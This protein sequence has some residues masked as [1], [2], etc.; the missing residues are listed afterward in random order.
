MSQKDVEQLAVDLALDQWGFV[1]TAQ[2]VARGATTVQVRRLQQA[3][4][5]ERRAQGLHRLVRFP[6]DPHE[7]EHEAYIGLDPKRTLSD[8]IRDTA[9]SVVA[10]GA[11]AA[12]LHSGI[13]DIPADRIEFAVPAPRKTRLA[14]VQLHTQPL[15]PD[16]WTI[17]DGMH[18]TTVE[19]TITD[20]ARDHAGDGGHLASVVKDA[21][22]FGLTRYSALA[23]ALDPVAE[24]WGF[25]TGRAFLDDLVTMDGA[26][27]KTSV[28]LV[29]AALAAGVLQLDDLIAS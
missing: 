3:G 27:S 29:R 24:T 4:V 18:V 5:L 14:G 21:L 2:L 28:E 22:W 25:M 26:I 23:E 7:L 20:L 13:G 17:V 9:P 15:E 11:T 12:A 10:R 19:R 6:D 16:D 8:R 1:T